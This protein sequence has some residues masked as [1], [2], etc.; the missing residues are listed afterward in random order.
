M[1]TTKQKV[2]IK[3]TKDGLV[4]FMDDS[5]S[6]EDLVS[7]LKNKVEFSHQQILSGPVI[8]IT[9]NLG[10]RYLTEKQEEQIRQIIRKRGNLVIKE[11][12]SE[13]ISREQAL[14]ERLTSQTNIVTG[15]VRSGQ[16]N[17]YQGDVLLLG[18]INPGGLVKASGSIFVLGHL[19]GM[20]HAGLYG[21]E[22][23]IIAA[24]HLEPTRLQIAEVISLPAEQW[25][26]HGLSMEF[27][28]LMDG[29]MQIDSIHRIKQIRPDWS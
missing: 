29:K 28:Y 10:Y 5:C 24:S 13:V 15:T 17:E 11:F 12:V 20:A 7:D 25:V 9:V 23:A 18:D 21:D 16:V 1:S 2:T 3:G 26:Q 4:F 14:I 6:F 22:R 19:R 27:A 8:H